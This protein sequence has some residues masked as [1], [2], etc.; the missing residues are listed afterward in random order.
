MTAN[1]IANKH[2]GLFGRMFG[3]KEKLMKDIIEFGNQNGVASPSNGVNTDEIMAIAAMAQAE[4]CV[5]TYMDN[6]DT[7]KNKDIMAT[8]LSTL[9]SFEGRP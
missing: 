2:T 4:Y 9:V 8:L 7:V 5:K 3:K 6:A 1:E